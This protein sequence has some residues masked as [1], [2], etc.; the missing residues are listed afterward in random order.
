MLQA[1]KCFVLVR[2]TP[3]AFAALP[4]VLLPAPS[5]A[6]N[7]QGLDP[8][9]ANSNVYTV[10]EGLLLK[11]AAYHVNATTPAGSL[12]KRITDFDTSWADGALLCHIIHSHRRSLV[13]G[14][15]GAAKGKA[16][17]YGYTQASL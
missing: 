8:E 3:A 16:P 6:A 11:W 14:E 2:L 4:G 12:P 15:P 17:L 13:D 7:K 1:V 9:L 10:A 5:K